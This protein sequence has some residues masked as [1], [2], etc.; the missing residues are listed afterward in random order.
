MCY[1]ITHRQIVVV[2]F[3]SLLCLI[4][5]LSHSL[6]SEL[7]IN[8]TKSYIEERPKLYHTN[9]ET[10][11]YIPP[12]PDYNSS[13]YPY[14]N[15]DK[16][17]GIGPTYESFFRRGIDFRSY[18]NEDVTLY[19]RLFKNISNGTFVELGAF[20]GKESSN[21]HFYELCLGWNGLLIEGNP[22][23]YD[24]LVYNRPGSHKMNFAPSCNNLTTI[25]FYFHPFPNSGL[26]GYAKAYEGRHTFTVPCGPLGPVLQDVFKG[27]PITFFS[28]DV[29]GSEPLVLET[30]DFDKIFIEVIMIE[31]EN[32]YCREECESRNQVR[33]KMK[34]VGYERFSDIVENS[35]IYIHSNSSFLNIMK[36]QN[37]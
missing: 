22:I 31:V 10:Y 37:Y 23:N 7:V 21:T 11:R 26:A 17:C 18:M 9:Y 36:L 28:L 2:A 14:I 34:Q 33:A 12:A 15:R 35:D 6:I 30:I 19:K 16:D 27:Q 4:L 1:E 29:E 3:Y 25:Q 32:N 20:N 8:P 24:G 5:L 13:L